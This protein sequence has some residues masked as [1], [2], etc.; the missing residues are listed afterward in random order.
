VAAGSDIRLGLVVE[1][2]L[3]ISEGQSV[4]LGLK[5][6]IEAQ[7][8]IEPDASLFKRRVWHFAL[9]LNYE[10]GQFHGCHHAALPTLIVV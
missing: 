4:S 2:A 9:N 1:F 8:F 5:V 10:I 7:Q 6:R 3:E